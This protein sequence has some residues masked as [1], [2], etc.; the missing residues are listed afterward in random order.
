MKSAICTFESLPKGF[1]LPCPPDYGSV[2]MANFF[3]LAAVK[4]IKVIVH[5]FSYYVLSLR[6][7]LQKDNI[8]KSSDVTVIVPT[9]GDYGREFHECIKSILA[10]KPSRII[11]AIVGDTMKADQ[12][13]KTLC[14]KTI[15]VVSIESADKRRQFLTAAET[16][17]TDI[18][19]YSDDHVFWPTTFLQSSLTPFNDEKVGLVGTVKR[20]I[21]DRGDTLLESMLNYIAV[22]YLER[23]NF[24]C[25]ASYN[26]DG[27]V[28]VISGRTAAVRTE[29]VQTP[30]FHHDYLHG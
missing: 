29:I 28:F 11:V 10:N 22:I 7:P 8:Y 9:V 6:I 1:P 13:C 25:T 4:F 2:W 12:I 17:K 18:I 15:D 20:V 5:T 30:E 16:V 23:H 24:E 3:L 27:G 21:R 14:S 26:I 19:V